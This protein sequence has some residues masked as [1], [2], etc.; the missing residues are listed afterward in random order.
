MSA[1]Y[2]IAG[3]ILIVVAGATGQGRSMLRSVFRGFGWRI[4]SE[5]ARGIM[6]GLR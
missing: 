2:F 3:A 4:G 6:R 5:I 1:F